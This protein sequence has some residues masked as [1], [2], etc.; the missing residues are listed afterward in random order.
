MVHVVASDT[1]YLELRSVYR[2]PVGRQGLWSALKYRVAPSQVHEEE[3][4]ITSMVMVRSRRM[5]RVMLV[6]VVAVLLMVQLA[7]AGSGLAQLVEPPSS[8]WQ[9]DLLDR[10]CVTCHNDRVRAGELVL[11]DLDIRSVHE[12]PATW[13]TWMTM[14]MARKTSW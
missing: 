1:S 2:N 11:E 5:P 6:L 9:R 12:A 13:E 3:G 7:G 4:T 10:Y 14:A 8:S